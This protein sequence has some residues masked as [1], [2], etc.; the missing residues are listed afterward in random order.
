M[1]IEPFLLAG[2][3]LVL[4]AV[5]SSR[6]AGTIGVP[7]LLLFIGV[8]MLAGSEGPGQIEFTDFELSQALGIGALALILFDGG[9]ST[10]WRAVR[11]VLVPGLTLATV[12]V[13]ATAGI[14]GVAAAWVFDLPLEVGLLMGS[15]VSS[16]DA[17]A[18]F[19]I[20]RTRRTGLAGGLQPLL[21][22]ESGANDPMAAFLTIACIELITGDASSWVDLVPMLVQQFAVGIAVGVGAGWLGQQVVNRI[23]LDTEGLYPV[24]TL[25]VALGTYGGAVMLGG[26]GFVAAYVCGLWI[27]NSDLLHKHS[28]MR[29]HAAIAWLCQIAMF[30]VLGLLVFPS[31]LVEIAPES[32]L[33]VAVLVLVARPVATYL[34][35][36]LFR[37]PWRHQTLVAWVGLRGATP[38]VLAT[39]PLVEGVP[40]APLIFD[41]VFFV[42]LISVLLQGTTIDRFARLVGVAVPTP[43]VVPAPLEAGQP[44]PDGTSLRELEVLAGSFADG[45]ALLELHLPERALVVL[46]NRD[47][48]YIVPT[49]AT[50]LA[51]G[52]GLLLLAPDEAF[53]R[54]RDLLTAPA[55][56]EEP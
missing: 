22:L 11:P 51:A 52:D 42:V 36:T 3:G 56:A 5:V 30:L 4:V 12:G 54:S 8:G 47:G 7:A 50:R 6:V 48:T 18:V 33:I 49:G 41:I 2:A 44:L 29:F 21:E 26:S 17:A 23:G 35:L 55:E 9:I 32:L 40:D 14:T 15:I 19:S 37:T 20:L 46:V 45:R 34:F 31:N 24:I 16:T 38:I 13:V 43:P 53:H 10:S 1:T 25:A 39:F 28:L 27:G